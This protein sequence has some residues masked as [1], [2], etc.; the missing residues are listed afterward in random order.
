MYDE[1]DWIFGNATLGAAAGWAADEIRLVAELG[2]ALAQNGRN[3][4]AITVFEGL[5]TLLV[6]FFHAHVDAKS[7]TG[8]ERRNI[9]AQPGFLGLD[10]RVHMNLRAGAR[11]DDVSVVE[12]KETKPGARPTLGSCQISG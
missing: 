8:A 2:Y 3:H 12:H 9:R 10:E 11:A 5:N 4:E 7:V 6:A 1:K